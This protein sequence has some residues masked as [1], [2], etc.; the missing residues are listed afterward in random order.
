MNN[1]CVING[2]LIINA[3]VQTNL[4]I[5]NSVRM[6]NIIINFGILIDANVNDIFLEVSSCNVT[7]K[8]EPRKIST[9]PSRRGIVQDFRDNFRPIHIYEGP[10]SHHI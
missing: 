5:R 2:I 9:Y 7:D 3:M 4:K 6:I 10:W 8:Y 1:Y